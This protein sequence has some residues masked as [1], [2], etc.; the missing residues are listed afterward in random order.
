MGKKTILTG[1]LKKIVTYFFFLFIASFFA[2]VSVSSVAAQQSSPDGLKVEIT[3]LKAANGVVTGNMI[4]K[5]MD[6]LYYQQLS[7]DLV[8]QTP[9]VTQAQNEGDS[10]ITMTSQGMLVSY[11][12]KDL[13]LNAKE[14][15]TIPFSLPYNE[16]FQ[17]GI[18]T[19]VVNVTSRDGEVL[20]YNTNQI[21]LRTQNNGLLINPLSCRLVVNGI[22]YT[23]VDGPIIAPSDKATLNCFVTNQGNE[24]IT[25]SEGVDYAVR[26]L[27]NNPQAESKTY[28][29]TSTY[30]F[31]AKEQKTV[32]FAIP[33]LKEPQVY[34]GYLYLLDGEEKRVSASVPFRWIVPGPSAHIQAVSLDKDAYK[35]DEKIVATVVAYPSMDL[36][37]YQ[38]PLVGTDPATINTKYG[39]N[40][41]N[42]K[43]VT[44][45]TDSSGAVCGTKETT[46]P[47]TTKT[48]TWPKETVTMTAQ[49]DCLYPVVKAAV[50]YEKK[51]LASVAEGMPTAATP[52]VKNSITQNIALFIG[53]VLVLLG[54]ILGIWLYRRRKKPLVTQIAIMFLLLGS[55]I[56]LSKI[57]F[58]YGQTPSPTVAVTPTTTITST[59]TSTPTPTPIGTVKPP[60]NSP[61]SQTNIEMKRGITGNGVDVF[62]PDNYYANYSNFSQVDSA[63]SSSVLP[64][65]QCAGGVALK[66]VG[67]SAQE[68]TCGNKA[69]GIWYRISIDGQPAQLHSLSGNGS[70]IMQGRAGENSFYIWGGQPGGRT[71]TLN[72]NVPGGI[73]PG[74]HKIDVDVIGLGLTDHTHDG[75]WNAVSTSIE[76]ITNAPA[77]WSNCGGRTPC[78]GKLSYTW[79]CGP[80]PACNTAC[81]T[82]ADCDGA[83]DSCTACIPKASGTGKTC[84]KQAC[85]S[86]CETRDDCATDAVKNGNACT[87]CV[88]DATG[89]KTCQPVP[90]ATPTPTPVL[91]CNRACTTASDCAKGVDGCSACIPNDTGTGSSCKVPPACGTSCKKDSQCAG[92][93]NGCSIC[94]EAGKCT[95]FSADMCKCDGMDFQSAKG[96]TFF[97]GDDVTF[98]AFGKVEG[99]NINV[100]DLQSMTF[101]LYQSTL[102]DPNKATRI[103][104]STAIT[105]TIVQNDA[106]KVR[107]K[108]T[109]NQKIP[110][111]VPSGSLFRV[112]ATIKCVA[113][114]G[115][116][117]AKTALSSNYYADVFQTIRGL[118]SNT[119]IVLGENTED[120]QQAKSFF[121]GA[122]ISEKSCSIIKFYFE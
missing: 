116:L 48:G 68:F 35:K 67:Y 110:A 102:K 98:I 103:A 84:Q 63:G 26:F 54:V 56:G 86:R 36:S 24:Q 105:P 45:V 2:L 1:D 31:A 94:G 59:P 99:S 18:Y 21:S 70:N 44:T 73:K 72:A 88:A 107:Y 81:T 83:K 17:S 90:T 108:V 39:T 119:K 28:R 20:A 41:S 13:A 65:P 106:N 37:W 122:K 40:L 15:K 49:A 85:N 32:S 30:S 97:P 16:A 80:P 47:P 75:S 38:R 104:Q 4:V 95:A 53:S 112:Q 74:N 109:W 43:L 93:K 78:Y 82:P 121:P 11:I 6:S 34:E 66:L 9:G 100:A 29:H 52:P 91:T 19:L 27:L 87:E 62:V 42:A 101:S 113:K 25:V 51:T 71:A 50:T 77:D 111:T 10:I 23:T 46:L 12:H 8:L 64:D 115:V 7:Y 5:N 33:Q 57:D 3:D 76:D 61:I 58:V 55:I 89:I 69:S 22:S 96:T 92:A 79:R 60:I 114:P 14:V 120:Q 117:G 118:L